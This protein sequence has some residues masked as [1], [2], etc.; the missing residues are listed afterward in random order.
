M[1]LNLRKNIFETNSSSVHAIVI[2]HEGQY[3]PKLIMN[4]DTVIAYCHDY[5]DY[6]RGESKFL[7]TQQEKL[8]YLVSWVAAKNQYHYYED[9]EDMWEYSVLLNAIRVVM[10][11]I[12][13]IKIHDTGKAAFDHQNSPIDSDCVVNFYKEDDVVSFIFND[14]IMLECYFD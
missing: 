1:K 6:G 8:D 14:S 2:N 10:P 3:I 5:S 13:S 12:K 7:K 9:I 11:E 4:G